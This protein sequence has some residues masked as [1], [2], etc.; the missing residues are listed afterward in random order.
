MDT[1]KE[2]RKENRL[3]VIWYLL[4]FFCF[5][6]PPLP[7]FLFISVFICFHMCW[8][9][10]SDT[11]SLFIV[12]SSAHSAKQNASANHTH[13][14]FLH[15]SLTFLS[16]P[17]PNVSAP[18]S[19][20]L[21]SPLLT[22]PHAQAAGMSNTRFPAPKSNEYQWRNLYLKKYG[23]CT[24]A[25][26]MPKHPE[27]TGANM[28]SSS[29][30]KKHDYGDNASPSLHNNSTSVDEINMSNTTG[31]FVPMSNQISSAQYRQGLRRPSVELRRGSSGYE[32]LEM[33]SDQQLF[34]ANV[35]SFLN[36]RV[37]GSMSSLLPQT[38][39]ESDA[40]R[41]V[42]FPSI[43]RD[44]FS[45]QQNGAGR[46][47][48]KSIDEDRNTAAGP[49][50]ALLRLQRE[51]WQLLMDNRIMAWFEREAKSRGRITASVQRRLLE[52]VTWTPGV[53]SRFPARRSTDE[54]ANN[55]SISEDVT[56]KGETV[57]KFATFS[58]VVSASRGNTSQL[59]S[60][61]IDNNDTGKLGEEEKLMQTLE[62]FAPF[63]AVISPPEAIQRVAGN[64]FVG[65]GRRR[66]GEVPS[67]I[68]IPLF[69]QYATWREAYE[70]RLMWNLAPFSFFLIHD[71]SYNHAH[72]TALYV[73]LG[74]I[75]SNAHLH[76]TECVMGE[77]HRKMLTE[78]RSRKTRI[79]KEIPPELP[80]C[81]LN[82]AQ[83]LTEDLL[84]AYEHSSSRTTL[85]MAL[86]VQEFLLDLVL[87]PETA[88]SFL[89]TTALR[90]QCGMEV[91][92]S[93]GEAGG[94]AVKQGENEVPP[95]DLENGTANGGETAQQEQGKEGE[96]GTGVI[97]ADEAEKVDWSS[98]K[99]LN[100][101]TFDELF[102]L[103]NWFVDAPTANSLIPPEPQTAVASPIPSVRTR[104]GTITQNPGTS[105]T[106]LHEGRRSI[107]HH[108]PSDEST[109]PSKES[110]Y[111]IGR[112][113]EYDATMSVVEAI[114]RY[115]LQRQRITEQRLNEQQQG[116]LSPSGQKRHRKKRIF[117][118]RSP[119][120]SEAVGMSDLP[121]GATLL[122]A[123]ISFLTTYIRLHGA[124]W[125][126]ELL[127]RLVNI[128]RRESV[129]LYVNGLEVGSSHCV[130]PQEPISPL[131]LSGDRSADGMPSLEYESNRWRHLGAKE[132]VNH[133]R[134]RHL[135]DLICQDI[136]YVMEEFFGTLFGKRSVTRL[137]QGI[138]ILLTSF[139]TTIHLHLL[140]QHVS[141]DTSLDKPS[142]SV[143]KCLAEIR[144]KRL[145]GGGSSNMW[146]HFQ[147][148]STDRLIRSIENNRLAKF[149]LFD[150]WILPVLNNAVE[151]GYI[152]EGSS[153]HLRWNLDAFARYLKIVVNAAIVPT[154]NTDVY[155]HTIIPAE[156]AAQLRSGL[157]PPVERKPRT[158]NDLALP[159]RCDTVKL[160]PLINGIYDIVS[161]SLMQL[162]RDP[163]EEEVVEEWAEKF[164]FGD[165]SLTMG[166]PEIKGAEEN[167]SFRDVYRSRN[168]LSAALS[169]LNESLGITGGDADIEVF[170]D[171]T[172]VT[173]VRILNIFCA[174]ASSDISA[175]VVVTEYKVAPS[176][177]AACV[178][179]IFL[180][181]SG[182]HPLVRDAYLSGAL[183]GR[184]RFSPYLTC[185]IGVLLHPR[186]ASKV[187]DNV[188]HNSRSFF[189]ALLK[190]LKEE[191]L[192]SLISSLVGTRKHM[193]L[194]DSNELI[195][196][197]AAIPIK[198]D[199]ETDGLASSGAA[200]KAEEASKRKSKVALWED[201][202]RRLMRQ[203]AQA[204]TGEML[205]PE[206]TLHP[207][208]CRIGPTNPYNS[209]RATADAIAQEFSHA[210]SCFDTWWRAMVVALAVKVMNVT[211]E[212]GDAKS[213]QW[214]GWCEARM[215][216]VQRENR[217]LCTYFTQHKGGRIDISGAKALS[218]AKE[219]NRRSS[220]T[221]A[222][223]AK[224][225]TGRSTE[226]PT[227]MK[228]TRGGSKPKK[229]KPAKAVGLVP[230]APTQTMNERIRTEH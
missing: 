204:T 216:E 71:Q 192:L 74:L 202:T 195:S 119:T 135:E 189:T 70:N 215:H 183:V 150:C 104:K 118:S 176:V 178:S 19:L 52:V 20:S 227:K 182:E 9:S 166:S 170:E 27:T 124:P 162:F 149:I 122:S 83:Q 190:P 72:V 63:F 32:P 205:P 115:E 2:G 207:L 17:A 134:L 160:P 137:P 181:A 228:K 131:S 117:T 128:L 158:Q 53:Q 26:P 76:T 88:S 188:S 208:L 171:D 191:G 94:S 39:T 147:Q 23:I 157:T 125:L 144:Q 82:V 108:A 206:V 156:A 138:S 163:G 177:V 6:P 116:T 110:G 16:L 99:K 49:V 29:S 133:Q 66:R 155:I 221:S 164:T 213:M 120:N 79:A 75:S 139:C 151:F 7:F 84:L 90:R 24:Y 121:I 67:I 40:S 56:V 153:N 222:F 214:E 127:G 196:L 209:L 201:A 58:A 179:K 130:T 14:L 154:D 185:L 203:R 184:L 47:Q 140:K 145:T 5:L 33:L 161:G 187:L 193:P 91:A 169:S 78:S 10:V 13:A 186:T 165:A 229:K 98:L 212:C 11:S 230:K 174:R 113:R 112:V 226:E 210:P 143:R 106:L 65:R 18:P 31:L 168:D 107:S 129:L 55:L 175:K 48:G 21:P 51:T 69:S 86:D 159:P 37:S 50:K 105:I 43:L 173:P 123:P 152:S 211:E 3:L 111:I 34:S 136:Q 225:P 102:V 42:R 15:P 12:F 217:S 46:Q 223:V 103:V 22:C 45:I 92:V 142:I 25:P 197:I 28:P 41:G 219:R 1:R 87:D 200:E 60:T 36:R 126:K 198:T 68:G 80:L 54:D 8:I 172:D 95:K 199:T 132:A 218:Y 148:D 4:L 180:V 109:Q 38:L 62:Q 59:L 224:I 64:L 146:S 100:A 194:V 89:S 167:S 101:T 141:V 77:R 93:D 85:S 220:S 35:F 44:P 61:S 114:T 97:P 96:E 73:L 81:P 30:R 57:K